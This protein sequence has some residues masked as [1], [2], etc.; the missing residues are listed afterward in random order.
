MLDTASY[1]RQIGEVGAELLDERQPQRLVR[2]L[3]LCARGAERIRQLVIPSSQ[4][5]M[6]FEQAADRV[7]RDDERS[8]HRGTILKARAAR[9]GE[10]R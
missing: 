3:H 6:G 2:R 7:A 5:T 9:H 4:R 10:P 1:L 8:G